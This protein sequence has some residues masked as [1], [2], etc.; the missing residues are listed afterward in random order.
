MTVGK[1]T[2]PPRTLYEL[3]RVRPNADE[4]ALRIAYRNAVKATHPDLNPGKADTRDRFEQI[5]RAYEILNNPEQRA[6][7]DELLAFERAQRRA[8]LRRVIATDVVTTVA[9]SVVLIGG[10]AMFGNVWQAPLEATKL[11]QI[12][13]HRVARLA[14]VEPTTKADSAAQNPPSGKVPEI[15]ASADRPVTPSAVVPSEYGRN[16]PV[17]ASDREA[18]LSVAEAAESAV[19]DRPGEPIA[20]AEPV[21]SH[22]TQSAQNA[23]TPEATEKTSG[24]TG[25]P[26]TTGN[27]EPSGIHDAEVAAP[28]D[29]SHQAESNSTLS[30]EASTREAPSNEAHSKETPSNEA[31]SNEPAA[32]TAV[33]PNNDEPVTAGKDEPAKDEP[34]KDS[35][36]ADVNEAAAPPA[37]IGQPA[38]DSSPSEPASTANQQSPAAPAEKSTDP[39]IAGNSSP[40]TSSTGSDGAPGPTGDTLNARM[41]RGDAREGDDDRK[42]DARP[43]PQDETRART[44]NTQPSPFEKSIVMPRPRPPVMA[45][46]S[47]GREVKMAGRPRERDTRSTEDR[48]PTRQATLENRSAPQVAFE[49]RTNRVTPVFGVGF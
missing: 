48:T 21:E 20:K 10:Y 17:V 22:N 31:P 5:V 16:P 33:A 45:R 35:A 7:Y 44:A 3:L 30:S 49:N 4:D 41:D 46:P 23:A 36:K 18:Q 34:A 38:G 37:N 11:V 39:S 19:A 1:H 24:T 14:A 25:N 15:G 47:L 8:G 40:A 42:N 6:D 9:L 29:T 28:A 13:E 2:R 26:E 32:S 12:A 27:D 43:D